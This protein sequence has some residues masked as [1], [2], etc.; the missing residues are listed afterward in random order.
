VQEHTHTSLDSA[1]TSLQRGWAPLPIPTGS[2]APTG[3]DWTEIRFDSERQLTEEF[4]DCNIGLILGAASNGLVDIDLDCPEAI[5]L[6]P[7][8]LP[9]TTMRHGR[10]SALESHYWYVVDR[11]VATAQYDDPVVREEIKDRQRR[12]LPKDPSLKARLVELRSTGGQTVIP[13]SVHPSGEVLEWSGGELGEPKQIAAEA[14]Q[15]RVRVMAA[16][17]LLARYWPA[18]GIRHDATLALAGGLLRSGWNEQNATYF[19][20]TVSE[21]GDP[22][23]DVK[24]RAAAVRSTAERLERGQETRGWRTLSE[25]VGSIVVDKVREWLDLGTDEEDEED[26]T[27]SGMDTS[28]IDLGTLIEE[29]VPDPEWV[30]PGMF[31]RAQIH[32]WHGEPGDGKTF[33]LLGLMYRLAEEGLKVLWLDEE[34]GQIQTARRLQSFGADATVLRERFVYH[35]RPGLTMD[36]ADLDALFR[37]MIAEK[38]DVVVMD[39]M[40]DMLGQA[41]I[42]EDNNTEVTRYIKAVVEPLKFEYDAAVIC[43]DHVTKSKDSRGKYARGAGAK[44]SKTDAAWK[45]VK[46]KDF[47]VNRVGMIRLEAD[48]DRDGWLE[49]KLAFRIGGRDGRTIL[50]A[51]DAVQAG[52]NKLPEGELH[53]RI[54]EFL[55]L[56]ADCEADA[57]ATRDVESAVQGKSSAIREALKE[58]ATEPATG[59]RLMTRGRT[60]LWWYVDLS[61]SIELDFRS[62]DDD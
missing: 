9:H 36:P 49:P 30:L 51:V 44:K 34:S 13:P 16:A 6:A 41:G 1:T 56:N 55:R 35:A 54:V 38:P 57:T 17:S 19:V 50:E 62:L 58:L 26:D 21:V 25:N 29:G 39:S 15:L 2:K 40:A 22:G 27:P 53:Q 42:D 60:Q 10:A 59:V 23:G 24:D 8:L 47:N 31:Y 48:K 14:L 45:V 32:W 7:S 43:I 18:S 33:M 5:A 11:E 46:H 61:E 52:G 3:K 12:G 20:T 37:Q 4:A 28:R